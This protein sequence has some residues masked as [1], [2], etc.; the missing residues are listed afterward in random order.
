M[1]ITPI[2]KNFAP[3]RGR[4][5]SYRSATQRSAEDVSLRRCR[6]IRY[7]D[8]LEDCAAS[9]VRTGTATSFATTS[10]MSMN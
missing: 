4:Q 5:V 10:V 3:S 2:T 1:I 9:E 7:R 8:A 6:L